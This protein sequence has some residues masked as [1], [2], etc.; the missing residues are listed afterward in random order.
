MRNVSWRDREIPK[1][2]SKGEVLVVGMRKMSGNDCEIPSGRLGDKVLVVAILI[3]EVSS[4][5]SG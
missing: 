3:K 2:R 5:T 4:G 1:G